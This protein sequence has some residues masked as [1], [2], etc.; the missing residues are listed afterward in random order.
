MLYTMWEIADIIKISKSIKL[1]MK[2]NN[3][4][5]ILQKKL[6]LTFWPTQYIN[7]LDNRFEDKGYGK[8]K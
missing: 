5:F 4:S 3:V 6:K 1:L 2:M 7:K 8:K